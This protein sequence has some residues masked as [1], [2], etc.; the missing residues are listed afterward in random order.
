MPRVLITHAD[1]PIGRRIVKTLFHD[2]AVDTIFAVG[3]A[4]PPRS[5]DR[6]LSSEGRKVIYLQVD[7]AKHRP[8][9]D[10]FHSAR[11]RSARID[12]VIYVPR[13]GSGAKDNPS[14]VGGIAERTEE[15]RL[16]LQFCRETLSVRDLIAIGSAFVYRMPPGNANRLNE[17]SELDLDP[18]APAEIRSWIDCD[19]LFHA[20]VHN[21]RLDVALLRVPTVVADG[22]YVYMNPA[23]VGRLGP[24]FRA[25][26]FD[27]ICAL[28]SDKDVTLAVQAAIRTSASG[29]FNISGDQSVPLSV[30]AS[31]TGRSSIPIPGP[32]LRWMSPATR[33]LGFEPHEGPVDCAQLRYGYTLDT[34][35]AE[36]ELGFRARY[37][38]GLARAGDGVLQVETTPTP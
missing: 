10:L 4:P 16:L 5:F 14:L 18:H 6:F 29:I 28:V 35:R 11:F 34:S 31:W 23:L 30:L 36:A 13:H 21:D 20:E 17:D 38:I 9:S 24:R 12:T 22:G 2:S 25:L 26:G 33:A 15:S 3:D 7:M 1:E 37:R 19:M 27:P 8:I 32:L